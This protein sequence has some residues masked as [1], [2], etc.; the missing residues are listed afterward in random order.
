MREWLGPDSKYVH[1]ILGNDSPATLAERLVTESN[2][3]DPAVR[4]A[5]WEG[6]VEAVTAS[7][8][9]MIQLALSIDPEARALRK[10]YEEQVEAPQVRGA[11][12][13]A[14]ARFAVHG[15]DTYPDAT[16]TLRITYGS[17]KGWEEKGEWVDP[18]T[19]TERLFERTTGE[20]PF[21]LPGTWVAARESLDPDTPFNF[22][23]RREHSL[24]RRRLLV[25]RIDEQDRR[26]Q[27]NYHAGGAGHGVR[28]GP[29][30]GGADR[31][32]LILMRKTACGA[33]AGVPI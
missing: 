12:M 2:L 24:H 9:P 10:Q 19:H 16:F 23:V 29:P 33:R 15:T 5:L 25:R 7:D 17:V 22:S 14:D 31:N 32:R 3:D 28:G 20:R 21:K 8:D 6:G 26:R 1:M 11:A 27:R 18:F 4:K 13:I 30:P